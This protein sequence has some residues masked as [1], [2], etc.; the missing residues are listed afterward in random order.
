MEYEIALVIGIVII[1]LALFLTLWIF[2]LVAKMA[3]RR[4]RSGL[5]WVI[6]SLF[7]TP[8]VSAILLLCLGETDAYRRR[9]II[10]EETLRY[11]T[12][13]KLDKN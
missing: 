9:R 4:G 10:E 1:L 11:R 8:I 2:I 13:S 6:F 5:F 7:T 12:R 3:T